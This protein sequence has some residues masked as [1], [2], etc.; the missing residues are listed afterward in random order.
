[1]RSVHGTVEKNHHC[2]L[3]ESRFR[4]ASLL[5][6]HIE[7][8]H[9]KSRQFPCPYCKSVLSSRDKFKLHSQ[10]LHEGRDLPPELQIMKPRVENF[11]VKA[12]A[13]WE[14]NT[15]LQKVCFLSLSLWNYAAGLEVLFAAF[16]SECDSVGLE[17]VMRSNLG[18]GEVAIATLAQKKKFLLFYFVSVFSKRGREIG[19][20][21]KLAVLWDIYANC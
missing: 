20:F 16:Q 18:Q 13:S 11:R 12:N 10:R 6:K 4:V 21:A 19:T 1:M 14:W 5:R 2:H 7:T 8:V 3:C 17:S 9:E 15:H